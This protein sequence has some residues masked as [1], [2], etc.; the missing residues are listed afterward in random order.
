MVVVGHGDIYTIDGWGSN[1]HGVSETLPSVNGTLSQCSSISS[2]F[3]HIHQHVSP[4]IRFSA[5]STSL[6]IHHNRYENT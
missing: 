3:A 6:I 5:L 1:P 4:D 2:P